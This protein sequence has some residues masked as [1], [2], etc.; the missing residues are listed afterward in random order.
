MLTGIRAHARLRAF[1][2]VKAYLV[3]ISRLCL[4]AVALSFL[5]DALLIEFSIN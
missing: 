2:E 1:Y 5:E 4:I 3:K